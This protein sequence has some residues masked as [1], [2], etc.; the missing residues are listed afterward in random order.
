V[1]RFVLALCVLLFAAPAG[2]ETLLLVANKGEDSL[3]MVDLVTGRELRRLETGANPHE[4]AVSPDGTQAAVVAYGGSGI[5]IFDIGR[6]ERVRTIDISPS[7]RPHGIAWLGDG[8]LVATAEGSG[9]LV[10]VSADG[11]GLRAIP[12]GQ[13]GTHMV[14]VSRDGTRAYTANMGSGSVSVIDLVA[15]RKLRDVPAGQEPEGIALTPDGTQLWVADRRGATVRVFDAASMRLR[16]TLPSGATPIRVAIAPDGRTA[17]VSNFGDGTLSLFDTG[18]L[19]P[20]RTIRVS[21]QAGFQQVTILFGPGGER[22]YV[23]ETGIDRVAEVDL[24][25]GEVIG[26]L[27]AGRNGDGL[28]IASPRGSPAPER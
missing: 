11:T 1:R 25:S 9:T 12:T 2:A 20:T 22:L 19:R 21:G 3:S 26:R 16:A 18:E 13:E 5:D 8:R 23:A 27:P 4:V 6:R 10:I 14:A 15:G 7:S 17:I 28:G 24:A